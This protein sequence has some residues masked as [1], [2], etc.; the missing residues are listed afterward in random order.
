MNKPFV[1]LG[2]GGHGAVVADIILQ[3]GYRLEG[4][5][6]DGLPVGTM[7]L[8]TPVLGKLALCTTFKDCDFVLAV[9]D[10]AVRKRL[11]Q[12]YLLDYTTVIHPA[13]TIG[14]EVSIGMG[15]VVM[16]GAIIN[17]RATVGR[18]SIINSGCI[19]EH[20]NCLSDFVHIGPGAVLGGTVS[21]GES[22]FI[23]IGATIRNNIVIGSSVIV[24][25][26]A[27]VVKD[28]PA[29][30]TVVGVPAKPIRFHGSNL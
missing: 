1:V 15:G 2:A 29:D 17:A 11:A 24:G 27:V 8:G 14:N 9:G 18:H 20:D 6:D 13:S 30:C 12:T 4:F 16:A 25:A 10:Q 7:I 22:T 3:N 5:L 23:G 26:G 19:V 28:I 21:V